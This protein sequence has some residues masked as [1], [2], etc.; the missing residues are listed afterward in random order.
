M[1]LVLRRR[2]ADLQLINNLLSGI[3]GYR[4]LVQAC[5]EY[6]AEFGMIPYLFQYCQKDRSSS[7][8]LYFLEE[9]TQLQLRELLIPQYEVVL[10]KISLTDPYGMIH[11]EQS[12]YATSLARLGYRWSQRPWWI[13]ILATV[14]IIMI[15]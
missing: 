11:L 9:S 5:G 15:S 1:L 3:Y 6:L 12:P 8:F 7:S 2:R 13:K 14:G 4:T 10:Q